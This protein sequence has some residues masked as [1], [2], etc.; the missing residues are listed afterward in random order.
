MVTIEELHD[1]RTIVGQVMA[2][3]P[4]YEW[5]LLS[6]RLGAT[7]IVKH[8]NH[9]PTGAFKVRGGL[10]YVE[11]ARRER[12]GVKGLI[13]ATRGNHGQSIA[14]AGQRFGLPVTIVVPLGNNPEK[15]DAMRALG[16]DLVEHGRDF[17]EA[18]EEAV[19]IAKAKGLEMVP[20]FHRDLVRGVATYALELFT[21]EPNLKRL[22]V[23]I[24]LGSGIC[25]CILVR[26]LLGLSTD[27]VGV[28]AAGAPSYALSLEAGRIVSTSQASTFADGVATRVPDP[29]AFEIIRSGVAGIVTVEDNE[30]AA[31]IRAY[32]TATHNLSEGAGA[33]GLAAAWKQR[34]HIAGKRVGVILS[35]GNIDVETF[36]VQVL[37]AQPLASTL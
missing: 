19:R 24:G 1:A 35:G 26:D 12:P 37:R 30:T 22:Y 2:P 36:K 34:D 32:W 7:V 33:L 6:S 17:D 23:P 9:L 11:R 16:A 15:N 4:Q 20:S 25:G 29:V 8:E 27:I 31:A 18:R 14:L 13:S 21:D 3:T 10:T 28:Q 5:P